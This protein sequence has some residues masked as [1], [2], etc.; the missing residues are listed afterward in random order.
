MLALAAGQPEKGYGYPQHHPKVCFDES[1][2]SVGTAVFVGS[3]FRFLKQE[4]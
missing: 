1:V 2:L 4:G 3:A